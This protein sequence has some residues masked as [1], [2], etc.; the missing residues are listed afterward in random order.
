[1]KHSNVKIEKRRKAAQAL[2]ALWRPESE[3]L[4]HDHCQ[5]MGSCLQQVAFG[6][7]GQTA[8]PAAASAARFADMGERPLDDLAASSLQS[9]AFGSPY[10]S[11]IVVDR[12]PILRRLVRPAGRM[13]TIGFGNVR[14]Y[15]QAGNQFQRACF[16]VA[17][18]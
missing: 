12:L 6:H 17:L 4:A 11:T 9:L 7:L 1:D 3:Q 15:A 2:Q 16:M 18:V 5:V 10:S 8:E 13:G 14:S